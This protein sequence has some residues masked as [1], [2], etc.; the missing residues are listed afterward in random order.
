MTTTTQSYTV[1][2]IG[3]VL[4]IV[5][6]MNTIA[7]F[8]ADRTG[9]IVA[10]TDHLLKCTV[11]LFRIKLSTSF[12][13]LPLSRFFSNSISNIASPRTKFM[14]ALR[15]LLLKLFSTCLTNKS[16]GSFSINVVTFSRAK[17]IRPAS[18]TALPLN[19]LA[20]NNALDSNWSAAPEA[21]RFA[22]T[23][24]FFTSTRIRTKSS[25]ILS[26]VFNTKGLAAMLANFI[27]HSDLKGAPR[28]ENRYCCLG[29]PS[30]QGAY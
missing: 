11:P 12:T 27:N 18:D 13:A 24:K 8:L 25:R 16:N 7:V 9:V 22:F 6:V 29:S 28:T 5:Y 21:S 17:L 19:Y 15:S 23:H 3:I 1:F 4:D 14:I 30:I 20:A 10:L 26:I 2:R